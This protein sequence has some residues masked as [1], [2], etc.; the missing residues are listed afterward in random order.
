MAQR[1]IHASRCSICN[2]QFP[3]YA[4]RVWMLISLAPH[5]TIVTEN[6]LFSSLNSHR[7]PVSL[8]FPAPYIYIYI[9]NNYK[10]H[11]RVKW[12]INCYLLH[13]TAPS[14][15]NAKMFFCS[16][17]YAVF[18]RIHECVYANLCVHVFA[19]RWGGVGVLNVCSVC[20]LHGDLIRHSRIIA[21]ALYN[22]TIIL[23][24]SGSLYLCGRTDIC[25]KPSREN[26]GL[27]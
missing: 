16:R 12:I 6:F 1:H 14:K 19:E 4:S 25:P 20:K 26:N 13:W 15:T 7:S 11:C 22:R 5:R 23:S 17:D 24:L 9:Y 8:I 10:A 2:P 21:H 18:L 27:M 3:I